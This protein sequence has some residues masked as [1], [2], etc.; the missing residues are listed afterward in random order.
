MLRALA[1]F[2]PCAAADDAAAIDI[3]TPLLDDDA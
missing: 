1:A 3:A 2:T